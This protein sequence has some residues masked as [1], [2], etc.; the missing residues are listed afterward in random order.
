[1]NYLN[2]NYINLLHYGIVLLYLLLEF[3]PKATCYIHLRDLVPFLQS[4][5]EPLKV[6]KNVKSVETLYEMNIPMY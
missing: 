3:D 5:P 1:M 2:N 6:K 4:L